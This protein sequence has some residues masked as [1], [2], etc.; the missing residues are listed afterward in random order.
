MN[1]CTHVYDVIIITLCYCMTVC[2]E[3][4]ISHLCIHALFFLYVPQ[5]GHILGQTAVCLLLYTIV[6][7]LAPHIHNHIWLGSFVHQLLVTFS[8]INQQQQQSL[9]SMRLYRPRAAGPTS[10][11]CYITLIKH[12]YYVVYIQTSPYVNGIQ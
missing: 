5:L 4:G 11:H 1:I 7:V 9:Q 10:G 8:D 3:V 6:F 2:N 12:L